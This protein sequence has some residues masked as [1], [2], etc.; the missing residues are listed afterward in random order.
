MTYHPY[1][2]Y[3]INELFYNGKPGQ[4]DKAHMTA[5][6]WSYVLLNLLLLDYNKYKTLCSLI[7]NYFDYNDYPYLLSE[8]L[9][10]I[11]REE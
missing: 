11:K 3:D 1:D 4:G 10:V 5:L 9:N 8:T 6:I 2:R 7:G